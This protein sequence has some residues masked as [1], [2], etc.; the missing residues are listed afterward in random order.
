V[1]VGEEEE[2]HSVELAA[3]TTSMADALAAILP[4]RGPGLLLSLS[5]L[6]G[7]ERGDS[8]VGSHS[9]DDKGEALLLPLRVTEA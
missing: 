8:G 5:A 9:Y 1:Q 7:G 3:L 4:P 2:G 6:V